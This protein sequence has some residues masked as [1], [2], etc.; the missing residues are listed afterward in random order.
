MT[1]QGHRNTQ[2]KMQ[3]QLLEKYVPEYPVAGPNPSSHRYFQNCKQQTGISLVISLCICSSF[4]LSFCSLIALL[5]LFP[6]FFLLFPSDCSLSSDILL[7]HID[8]L[9]LDPLWLIVP[10]FAATSHF[11]FP[12]LLQPDLLPPFTRMQRLTDRD[13]AM[14]AKQRLY[15]TRLLIFIDQPANQNTE[16]DQ[17]I[18]LL[19]SENQSIIH[20]EVVA[21]LLPSFSCLAFHTGDHQVWNSM[22]VSELW[23]PLVLCISQKKS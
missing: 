10:F 2:L 18:N 23:V 8:T 6:R 19:S 9:S 12:A 16:K 13:S 17:K 11:C 3:E 5:L 4:P 7:L 14:P 22:R 15:Y 20:P 21:G 1:F